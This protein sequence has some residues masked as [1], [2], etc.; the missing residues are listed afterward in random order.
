MNSKEKILRILQILKNTDIDH[1]I[2]TTGIISRLNNDYGIETERKSVMRDINTLMSIPNFEYEIVKCE[3]PNDG[4]YMLSREFEDYEL[5]LFADFISSGKY[6][7][8]SDSKIILKK[9]TDH[10]SPSG[11]ELIKSSLISYKGQKLIGTHSLEYFS[12]IIQAILENKKI[13]FKYFDVTK[14]NKLIHKR[15]GHVYTV[16]PYYTVLYD[17]EYFLIANTDGHNNTAHYRIELMDDVNFVTDKNA[18]DKYV[19]R[20]PITE[21]EELYKDGELVPVEKYLR[22]SVNLWT[23]ELINVKLR[24]K[25]SSR[26]TMIKYFG[27]TWISE[28]K[29]DTFDISVDVT[30]NEGFYRLIA[31]LGTNVT[32]LSPDSARAHFKHY[33]RSVLE[34]YEAD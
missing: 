9:I 3:N 23:G 30:D 17:N 32:I 29:D 5:K 34:Q 27:D 26:L 12:I 6:I 16:S 22:S 14:G 19:K 11:K 1:P 8:E 25:N 4:W 13:R 21:I 20:R 2:N 28:N 10:A 33:L 31:Q 15:S 24:C 7:S 18:P